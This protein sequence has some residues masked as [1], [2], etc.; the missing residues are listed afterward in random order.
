ML[1][2]K[3]AFRWLYALL[4]AVLVVLLMWTPGL[5][6]PYDLLGDLTD[7]AAHFALFSGQAAWLCW[8]LMSRYRLR[9]AVVLS[10]GV[11]VVF[12]TVTEFGQYFV[13]ERSVSIL[14]LLTNW[15]GAAAGA[16]LMSRMDIGP[17]RVSNT[18]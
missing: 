15:L 13:P 11:V 7:K 3:A 10:L 9:S 5:K 18:E 6:A 16:G 1:L 14:D 8:A 2:K 17:R 4:W 12:G